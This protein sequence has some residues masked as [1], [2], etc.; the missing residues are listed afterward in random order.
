MSEFKSTPDTADRKIRELKDGSPAIT[1]NAAKTG[2]GQETGKGCWRAECGRL[3]VSGFPEGAGAE[4][5]PEGPPEERA[6]QVQNSPAGQA[7]RRATS[8]LLGTARRRRPQLCRGSEGPET[9]AR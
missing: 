9:S 3:T 8:V 4:N 1:R 5:G 6:A 7:G 2:E